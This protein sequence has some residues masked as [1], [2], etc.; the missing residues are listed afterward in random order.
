MVK[1]VPIITERGCKSLG[2]LIKRFREAPK[3]GFP[4]GWS[5]D[6]FVAEI[7]QETGFTISK[8]TLSK[9]ERGHSEP[10]WDTL[11]ILAATGFLVN[12]KTGEPLTTAQLFEIACE[13]LSLSEIN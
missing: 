1:A 10:K 3:P 12:A 6:E 13:Q 7:Q 2:Q 8:S 9:L 4:K 11:A 5:L